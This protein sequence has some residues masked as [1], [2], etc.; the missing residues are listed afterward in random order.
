MVKCTPALPVLM[1]SEAADAEAPLDDKKTSTV[2]GIDSHL[3]IPSAPS[4][5]GEEPKFEFEI[6]EVD[7]L[8]RPEPSCDAKDTSQHAMGLVRVLDMDGHALGSW[9]P[10]LSTDIVLEML[11]QMVRMRIF[12]DR[13]MTM[14]RQGKLSFYMKCRGEEAV[15]IPAAMAL[16]DDDLLHPSYR[17]PGLLLAR[18]RSMVD[19]ICHC[20]GNIM[21]NVKGRQMPVHYS[22]KEGNLVSISSP[23]GTQFPQAVGMAMASAY[24]GKDNVTASW[25]GEGTSAQGDFH[26]ALTF[27][28]VYQPPVILNVVNNQWAIS[29][30]QNIAHGGTS[31]AARGLAYNVA[32]LRVDGNDALAVFAATAWAAERG[33]KGHGATLIELF[34]H[35]QSAH[36]S[37]DDPSRYRPVNEGDSWPL[38]D[39]IMRLKNHLIELRKWDERRHEDLVKKIDEEVITAY[40]EAESHGTHHDGPFPPIS[41]LFEDVYEKPLPQLIDQRRKL[42]R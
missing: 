16:R 2:E 20:I 18:G 27:A 4:R 6:P 7:A 19:M 29:T 22:W 9:N 26:H 13:M 11:T 41:T 38:G 30:H 23:V 10:E 36:S 1:G 15:A 32:S 33:R 21:D 25:L 40:K 39:P 17:Q 35:R 24:K 12:D 31:F 5:P 34:T 14:Q 28:S 8:E 42:G 3:E 37:S